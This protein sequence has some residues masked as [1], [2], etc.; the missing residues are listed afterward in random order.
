MEVGKPLV[1]VAGSRS[2]VTLCQERGCPFHWHGGTLY[3][4]LAV[5]EGKSASGKLSPVLLGEL[6]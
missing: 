4:D 5:M 3:M 6:W 2:Q 1:S